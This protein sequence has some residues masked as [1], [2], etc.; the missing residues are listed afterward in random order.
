MLKLRGLLLLYLK[1]G[2]VFIRCVCF[3]WLLLT[4][5]AC[6]LKSD[7]ETVRHTGFHWILLT[8][9]MLVRLA[10]AADEAY[11][12]RNLQLRFTTATDSKR[13]RGY[14]L[15]YPLGT[16]IHVFGLSRYAQSFPLTSACECS[17]EFYNQCAATSRTQDRLT[18]MWWHRSAQLIRA[19][20][21][22]QRSVVCVG[23]RCGRGNMVFICYR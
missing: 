15:E 2:R 6:T 17:I 23:N 14:K 9:S 1:T 5:A 16:Q 8:L 4:I 13:L 18:T 10:C 7:V 20:I 3:H 21:M 22:L 11:Q 12:S 19:S